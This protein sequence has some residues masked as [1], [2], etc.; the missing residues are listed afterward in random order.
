MDVACNS[1]ALPPQVT[2]KWEKVGG[3]SVTTDLNVLKIQNVKDKDTG[4]YRCTATNTEG[5]SV[6]TFNLKIAKSRCLI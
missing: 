1:D 6:E 5:S 3:G 4:L 2:Y